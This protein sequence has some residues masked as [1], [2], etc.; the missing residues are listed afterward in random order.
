[1]PIPSASLLPAF[2]WRSS[3][4][5]SLPWPSY[6][7]GGMARR[8]PGVD[9]Y[10]WQRSHWPWGFAP[11]SSSAHAPNIPNQFQGRYSLADD[12]TASA[13][14]LRDGH[15]ASVEL[16]TV[17]NLC[18]PSELH[19]GSAFSLGCRAE[20]GLTQA[21]QEATPRV[22]HY[23]SSQSHWKT[24]I[25]IVGCPAGTTPSLIRLLCLPAFMPFRVQPT[26]G[27]F[28]FTMTDN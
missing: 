10:P 28:R 9:L 2:P 22:K 25:Q 12:A 23:T 15:G 19:C 1:M 11:T 20:A 26:I 14:S 24:M 27:Y 16:Q 18:T 5:S 17:W 4:M 3:G 8:C 13:S 21:C 7:C 6:H